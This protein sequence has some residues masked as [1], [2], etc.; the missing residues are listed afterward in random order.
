M[1]DKD[2]LEEIK[3]YNPDKACDEMIE[4]LNRICHEKKISWNTLAKESGLSSSTISYLMRG[5]S[6]PQVYTILM[7][8]NV[9]GVR[10]SELFE[11][12]DAVNECE[13]EEKLLEVYRGLTDEK[14]EMLRTYIDMLSKYQV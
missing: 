13:N 9:L 14:R 5:K 1:M 12:S 2:L 10:F 6:R 8:C 7:L 4:A 11:E 3:M